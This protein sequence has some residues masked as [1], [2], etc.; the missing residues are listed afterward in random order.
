MNWKNNFS[1][2]NAHSVSMDDLMSVWIETFHPF[3]SVL[4][5]WDVKNHLDLLQDCGVLM[6]PIEAYD[7]KAITVELPGVLE[8]YELLDNIQ[9]HGGAPFMQVYNDGKLLSDNVGPIY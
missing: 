2:Q 6:S 5:I 3:G 4:V 1:F 9:D 7:N 8:A